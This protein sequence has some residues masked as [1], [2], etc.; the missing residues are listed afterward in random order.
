MNA[1]EFSKKI[2][3]AV[4]ALHDSEK[5]LSEISVH[6]PTKQFMGV[7][8]TVSNEGNLQGNDGMSYADPETATRFGEWLLEIFGG[9]VA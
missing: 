8:F 4:D 7:L 3:V 6:R 9:N 5:N 1:K 2:K